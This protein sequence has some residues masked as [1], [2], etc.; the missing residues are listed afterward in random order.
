VKADI[1]LVDAAPPSWWPMDWLRS[2]GRAA[3]I[4]AGHPGQSHAEYRGFCI[5]TTARE[6]TY[7]ARVT[8]HGNRSIR[9]PRQIRHHI[10]AAGF[11][12]R[13][14]AVQ[15]ARFVIASGA[16]NHLVRGPGGNPA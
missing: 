6:G 5:L 2:L 14:E 15:H 11:G 3:S 4:A 7:F 10:D 16:L 1:P 12:S 8:H 9:V 13:E